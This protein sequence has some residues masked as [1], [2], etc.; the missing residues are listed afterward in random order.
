MPAHKDEV[1]DIVSQILPILNARQLPDI[2]SA[3]WYIL[4]KVYERA[5]DRDIDEK[6]LM[7]GLITPGLMAMADSLREYKQKM[8]KTK[9]ELR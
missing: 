7:I 8:Q 4:T 1:E 6:A 2:N 5:M 3:L 9:E